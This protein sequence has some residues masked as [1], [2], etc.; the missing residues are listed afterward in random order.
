[1]EPCFLKLAFRDSSFVSSNAI[2]L[3][4]HF[5]VVLDNTALHKIASER[6]HLENPTFQQVNQLV[7]DKN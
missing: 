2:T 6:L 7:S 3:F 4:S 5:Q 1:M